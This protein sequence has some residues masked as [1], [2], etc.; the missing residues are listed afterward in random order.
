MPGINYL[1]IQN[2]P[3]TM[4]TQLILLSILLLLTRSLV[5]FASPGDTLHVITHKH[6]TVVTDPKKG[7]NEYRRWGVFP[8]KDIPV[9]KIVMHVN[10][11]CPDTLRC[12]DWDYS[13]RISIMRTGGVNGKNQ[14]YEIGRMLTPYGGAFAK[15]W[16]FEWE[17]DVTDFSLML[18]DSVEI[19]Y[20]HSGYE[21]ANDRGWA[22]TLDF[23]IIRG[24]PACEP[25]SITEVWDGNFPYGDSLKPFNENIPSFSFTADEGAG[26]AR[27]RIV[28]TGHG[29][30]EPDGCGEFCK[31][32]REI[33]LDGALIDSRA[34]WKK[35]GDNP[36]YPQAGTWIF[37]RAGW[38]PGYLMQPDAYDIGLNA[39]ASRTLSLKMQNYV[40]PKPSAAEVI[41]AYLIQYKKPKAEYDVSMADVVVPSSKT[42]YSRLNPSAS[43]I[44]VRVANSGSR[45]VNSLDFLYGTKGFK[46]KSYSWTGN[47]KPGTT[48]DIRLPGTVDARSGGNTFTVWVLRPGGKEDEYPA[49]N[50]LLSEFQNAPILDT[51]LVFY[52]LTNNQPSHNS[53]KLFSS[54]GKVVMERKSGSLK[55][56]TEYRD[57]LKLA[58]GAYQLEFS[59][60]AGDGLEF[61]YNTEGGRG[62][63]RLLN[64][65]G[66]LVKA[67][68]S[69]CGS[70]WRYSFISGSKPDSISSEALSVGLY[71]TRTKD[72]T[73]LDYFAN[74]KQ[75]VTVRLVSDPGAVTVEEHIYPNLREGRFT[76]DL[77]RYPSGRFYLKVLIGGVEKFNKR[78]RYTAEP[79]EGAEPAYEWPKDSLVSRNLKTWQ[80][81]KFGILIHWGAYS[82]WGVVESWSLC[83]ED[84]GWC[85]RRGPYSADWYTYK[86]AYEDIRKTFYPDKFHPEHWAKAAHE[87]GMKYV[88]FTTKHHD[89]FCNF[90]TKYTDYKITDPASAFSK[91]PRSNVVREVFNA[92]RQEGLA[93][94]AYFSKPDWH[95]PD[96]WWP[97]FPALDRNVNYD[98]AKYPERWD[99]FKKFTYNQLNEITAG[100]G[101]IDILWLDGGQVRPANTLTGETKPWLGKHQWIQDIDMPTIAKMARRNQPGLLIVDRT[102]HGEFE[103]YRTPE[104][105]IPANVPDYPWESCITLCGSWYHTGPGEQY[106]STNWAIHTLIRI[107]AKGGNLLLG[108][109]PDRSGEFAPEAYER[110][111]HIGEWMKVNGEAIYGSRPLAPYQQGDLC[112]TRSGDGKTRY[113]FILVKEG[114]FP[115]ARVELP[116]GMISGK[117]RITLLGHPQTIKTERKNGKIWIEIPKE[118][119]GKREPTPA[120]VMKIQ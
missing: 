56:K 94:G 118:K 86:K 35:C 68:E 96:Y 17:V 105:Q 101:K 40:S 52:L 16:H 47:I 107:V 49:D 97:Y 36:L 115:P 22:I 116:A 61:W 28:Q 67:F 77:R 4:R 34:I 76:Y 8:S 112:F 102:V 6:E 14:D 104:Q 25:L 41:S 50:T 74:R 114:E 27:L 29:M 43:G 103:N 30:D 70:G 87:A 32:I 109:G 13:D 98:P 37:D 44:Q 57:T 48:A 60:T 71:P 24:T 108:I 117:E 85:Q 38:C 82:E 62:V 45:E 63:A 12:A 78:I 20:N 113:V 88:V 69:D 55:E 7:T 91:N 5:S 64:G 11:G 111:E 106:K 120:L 26:F 100:Y 65:K 90:D 39:A 53:W 51:C 42:A 72:Y 89:G 18:R 21:P 95:S 66:Q 15:D 23:E 2:I 1:R 73:T 99:S 110:L 119:S 19:C 58:P 75:D 10:F 31:K 92:F 46:E 93:I 59:D 9:R 84:E 33:R 79:P 80:D 81:W 54:D 83:P 3:G